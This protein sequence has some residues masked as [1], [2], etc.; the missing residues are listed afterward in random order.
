[1]VCL[2]NI[3]KKNIIIISIFAIVIIS[4]VCIFSY[5]IRR[6]Y[7]ISPFSLQISSFGDTLEETNIKHI[8]FNKKAI[9]QIEK[10]GKVTNEVY[11]VKNKDLD[12]SVRGNIL[13]FASNNGLKVNYFQNHITAFNDSESFNG[14]VFDEDMLKEA[15][16]KYKD[17]V[18]D[19]IKAFAL[20]D[21]I[22]VSDFNM[23]VCNFVS[24][25]NDKGEEIENQPSEVSFCHTLDLDTD[26]ECEGTIPYINVDIDT[27]G[28]ITN[29][30]YVYYDIEKINKK[31]KL[32][33]LQEIKYDVENNNNI[34]INEWNMDTKDCT[35]NDVS[36][37]LYV[38]GSV[39]NIK[40]IVPYYKLAYIEG[41]KT[42]IEIILPAI[43]N[44][45]MRL[46]G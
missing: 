36:L 12:D 45:Y 5:C 22:S 15:E 38:E 31:Y 24:F 19:V 35:I 46:M 2:K 39:E 20:D 21:K 26:M 17:Q 25:T 34:L 28:K 30:D 33:T 23:D 10:Y 14:T 8:K 13:E 18:A 11:K 3:K 44:K 40:Y 16:T 43:K 1:M 42:K 37:I 9:E 27:K 6:N 32:K 7:S 4:F 41:E 29:L